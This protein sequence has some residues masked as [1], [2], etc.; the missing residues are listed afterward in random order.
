MGDAAV[1]SVNSIPSGVLGGPGPAEAARCSAA[2]IAALRG[3]AGPDLQLTSLA[4]E[5]ASQH[6]GEGVVDV[7]T[8]TDKRARSIVFASVEARIG[9]QV[10]FTAQGLFSPPIAPK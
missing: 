7:L 6:I 1:V 9:A 8:R 5:L 4:M 2:A 3:A 10:V